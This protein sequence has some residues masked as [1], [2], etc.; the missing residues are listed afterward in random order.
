M[1]VRF[2]RQ[3]V[4]QE[5]TLRL[6]GTIQHGVHPPT[7]TWSDSRPPDVTPPT[8]SYPH[9]TSTPYPK[10]I[11]SG[12]HARKTRVSLLDDKIDILDRGAVEASPVKQVF[13]TVSAIIALVRVSTLV[14]HPSVN[15]R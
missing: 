12:A 1:E 11:T 5:L 6:V 14:L 13:R 15:S 9:S 4:T 7:D 10:P 8:P 3:R 2:H